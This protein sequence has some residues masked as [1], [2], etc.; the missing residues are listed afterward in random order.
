MVQTW[1]DLLFAHWPIAPAEMRALVPEPLELDLCQDQAWVAVTPF[2]I[3]GLRPRG[4][5]PL[6][7]SARFP[8]L[9][10]R[11][12]VRHRGLPGVYFFSLDA[13]SRSAVLGAR[14]AYGLPY[15]FSDM[16]LVDAGDWIRYRSRR[17]AN[18][19]AEFVGQYRPVGE[20]RMA[21]PGSIEHFLTERYC[22]YTVGVRGRVRRAHIHHVPWQLQRAEARIEKNTKA[23]AAGITLP[24]ATPLLHFSGAMKVLVWWPEPA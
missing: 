5:P 11:T 4:L 18:P 16:A 20:P 24:G 6:P 1:Y 13:G 2:R 23:Q 21:P 3:A 17:V 7:G 8:E 10:V 14:L 15:F 19:A 22:L 12:Y 9:N